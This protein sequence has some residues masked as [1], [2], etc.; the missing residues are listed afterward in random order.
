M[1]SYLFQK[2]AKINGMSG[3]P[4]ISRNMKRQAADNLQNNIILDSDGEMDAANMDDTE[5]HD[6]LNPRN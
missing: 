6:S 4:Q 1:P 5:E 2:A 3:T